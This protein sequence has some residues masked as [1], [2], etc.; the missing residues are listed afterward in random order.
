MNG[1]VHHPRQLLHT[2]QHHLAPIV[3][4]DSFSQGFESKGRKMFADKSI[5]IIRSVL[6]R[7]NAGIVESS[8][9]RRNHTAFVR[10]S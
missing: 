7:L 1:A 6:A 2:R 8:P 10:G 5:R 3:A 4:L 9:Q